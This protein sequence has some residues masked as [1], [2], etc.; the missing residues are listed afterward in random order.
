MTYSQADTHRITTKIFKPKKQ[1]GKEGSNTVTTL[2]VA[3][4]GG[5]RKERALQS[6]CGKERKGI[7]PELLL[8]RNVSSPDLAIQRQ[9]FS[10]L[11]P[12]P[13]LKQFCKSL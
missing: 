10:T 7:I 11:H 2:A 5:G 6:H 4:E 9:D 8:S 1:D 13:I 12:G 3:G